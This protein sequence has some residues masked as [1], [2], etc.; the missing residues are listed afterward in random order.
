M[1]AGD[2]AVEEIKDM[3]SLK[4]KTALVTG[5]SRGLGFSIARGFSAFGAD[6]IIA[7]RGE[8][9]LR[10]AVQKLSPGSGRV[11]SAK[12]DVSDFA[13]LPGFFEDIYAEAGGIDI[14]VNNAGINIRAPLADA[15]GEDFDSIIGVNLKG[16]FILSRS[17]AGKRVLEKKPG[18]IINVTSLLAEGVRP[19]I[20]IY[21]ASKGGLKQ[22]TKA[23]AV[24]FGPL[25]INTNAIGPGYYRTPM[26]DALVLDGGF[27]AWVKDKTPAGRWGEPD[28]IIG[29]AVFLASPASGYVNGQTIYVDGGWLSKL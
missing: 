12:L 16:A 10:E 25:G 29:A 9:S 23:F 6:V 26:N 14:L 13:S 15:T 11:I 7:A 5:G 22:L 20:G 17:F 19:G 18:R 21:A 1:P 28:E 24:E 27:D 4:G 2:A 3:F 8:D